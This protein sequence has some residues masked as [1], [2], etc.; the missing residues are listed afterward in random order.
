MKA[1]IA[2]ALRFGLP[3][4]GPARAIPAAAAA[5]PAPTPQ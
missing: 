1:A 5:P 2:R 3:V 4:N